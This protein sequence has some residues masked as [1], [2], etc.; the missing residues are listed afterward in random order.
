MAERMSAW[1]VSRTT[2]VAGLHRRSS[3]AELEPV[4]VGHD[5]VHHRGREG[6]PPGE[7]E[8]LAR[9]C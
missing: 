7:V 6:R 9:G 8:R 3:R 1:P 2:S 4:H 5:E